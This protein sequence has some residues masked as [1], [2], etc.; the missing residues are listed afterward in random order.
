MWKEIFE[1]RTNGKKDEAIRLANM[2]MNRRRLEKRDTIADFWNKRLNDIQLRDDPVESYGG[3]SAKSNAVTYEGGYS[4]SSSS[5]SRTSASKSSYSNSRKISSGSS[6]VYSKNEGNKSDQ[7]AETPSTGCCTCQRGPPGPPGLRGRD[8]LRGLDGETGQLGPQGP[9]A[10]PGPDS[11]SLFPP[12]CPCE[13]AIGE[14]GLKGPP[15]ADGAVGPPVI[16]YFFC[17]L[18]FVLSLKK[19]FK[20][21]FREIVDKTE[22]QVIKGHVDQLVYKDNQV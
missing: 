22:N 9:P 1:I 13:A 18:Q 5:N 3:S 7:F 16:F 6:S 20:F 4:S 12:Q 21:I 19:F 10:P 2:V 11:I 15:G 8:G 14:T 17:F